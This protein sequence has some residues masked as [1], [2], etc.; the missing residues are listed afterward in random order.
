M[1]GTVRLTFVVA[2]LPLARLGART[3]LR[4][5]LELTTFLAPSHMCANGT[6]HSRRLG[7][8]MGPISRRFRGGRD[9]GPAGRGERRDLN[10][11]EWPVTRGTISDGKTHQGRRRWCSSTPT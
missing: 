6:R 8:R 9:T 5:A 11:L 4:S 7:R 1:V 3:S 2:S 10:A